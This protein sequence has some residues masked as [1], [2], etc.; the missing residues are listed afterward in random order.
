MQMKNYGKLIGEQIMETLEEAKKYLQ[1]N[2]KAGVRCPCCDRL[3]KLYSYSINT[4]LA[5]SLISLYQLSQS[6]IP[7]HVKDIVAGLP[8][9]CGKNFCILKHWGLIKEVT[10]EDTKKRSSGFW[11]ITKTGTNFVLG[12]IRIPQ[13]VEVYNN[14]VLDISDEV[15][16]IQDCL[17][18]EFDY[19]ELMG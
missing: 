2:F 18:K 10:N 4:S 16:T 9:S 13:T 11:N 7:S 1:E 5:R 14:K 3:V 19:Q 12:K 17:G 15:V 8:H 6:Q